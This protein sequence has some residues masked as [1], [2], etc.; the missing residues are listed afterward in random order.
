MTMENEQCKKI[1]L[2]KTMLG[3]HTN[4]RRDRSLVAKLKKQWTCALASLLTLSFANKKLWYLYVY[5]AT[6]IIIFSMVCFALLCHSSYDLLSRYLELAMHT[7]SHF[8][9]QVHNASQ[10]SKRYSQMG[11]G[12]RTEDRASNGKASY[13]LGFDVDKH[14]LAEG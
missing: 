5:G 6:L 7:H 2:T 4:T 13:T 14:V 9:G 1:D 10:H 11:H 8:A 12:T 3:C